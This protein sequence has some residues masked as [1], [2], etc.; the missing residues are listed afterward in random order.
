ML[1]K[2]KFLFLL[3]TAA[4]LTACGGGGNSPRAVAG[5]DTGGSEN[6]GGVAQ[7]PAGQTPNDGTDGN[8]TPADQQLAG[9]LALVANQ[10][11]YVRTDRSIYNAITLDQFATESGLHDFASGSA[12]INT[13][14]AVPAPVAAPAAPI[15]A[16]G[17]RVNKFVQASSGGA[18]AG[19]QTVVGR[20]AFSFTEREGSAGIAA[21]EMAEIMRFVIDGVELKTDERGELVSAK[22]LEG[23]QMHVYGRNAVNTEVRETIAVPGNAV[24]LLD[25]SEVLDHYGD[26]GSV[27]LLMDLEAA[28]SQA[29]QRLIALEEIRGQFTMHVTLSTAKIVRPAEAATD[30]TPALEEMELIGEAITV[31]NQPAVTGAGISGNAW[32]RMYP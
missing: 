16:F 25:M 31:N 3:A 11:A 23:A 6:T 24:R 10:V 22:V 28:F 20:V 9:H 19:E 18:Q 15:A 12:T 29:G 21:N 1:V 2:K 13:S 4:F 27:V 30:I 26:T 17:L 32:I 14:A 8:N 5:V 7:P